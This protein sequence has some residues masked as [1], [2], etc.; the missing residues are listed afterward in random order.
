M[1]VE[2]IVDAKS[3]QRAVIE[4]KSFP[5]EMPK[6][7]APALNRTVD[8]MATL[9]SREV[10]KEYAIKSKD[11]MDTITKKK[12]SPSNLS[13]GITSHGRTL[14]LYNHFRVS[15]KSP[16]GKKYKVKV[17]IK[18]G[19]MQTI[20]TEPKPFIASANNST[21][22]FKRTGKARTPIVVLRSL[23]VPQMVS[24][25]A[26]YARIQTQAAE[27]LEKR[28]DHEINRKI[29]KITRSVTK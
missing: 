27:M 15:P 28:I 1:A 19:K 21:Q 20:A 6:A 18:K 29:D 23:S 12:A 16:T 2:I 25:E 24:N 7:I 17:A 13:A 22:V 26:T 9:T 8:H 11:I 14:T 10:R 3:V 5:A 4:L